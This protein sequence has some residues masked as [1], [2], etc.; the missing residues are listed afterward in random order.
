[1]KK[2][3]LVCVLTMLLGMGTVWAAE[4]SGKEPGLGEKTATILQGSDKALQDQTS[5]LPRVAFLYVNNAKTDYDAEID[6]KILDHMKKVAAGRWVL[7]AGDAYKDKLASMGIQSVTMAERADILAV[8]KDSD[9]DALLVVE[10]EPFTVSDVMTFFTVGKKV[11]ASIPVKAI[12]RHT[13]LYLYNGKFVEMGQDN[14]MI[15]ALGN[16]SVSMKAL[17]QFFSKFDA[18]VPEKFANVKRVAANTENK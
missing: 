2:V 6:A 17:D 9:A 3:W 13:G 7:V 1:M 10:I 18:V 8:A 11:T 4:D 16:K 12:D 5:K 14:T 15:G